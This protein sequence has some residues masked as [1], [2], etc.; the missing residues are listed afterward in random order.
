MFHLT[1]QMR[2]RA[3][4]QH[5]DLSACHRQ[6]DILTHATPYVQDQRELSEARMAFNW[7]RAAL[8]PI[9]SCL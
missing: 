3:R 7:E 2:Y 8:S 5:H 1:K 9:S 6:L 4:L